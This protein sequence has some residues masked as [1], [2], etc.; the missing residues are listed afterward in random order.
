MDNSPF[1]GIRPAVINSR[2]EFNS[3]PHLGWART[4]TGY[5]CGTQ[6]SVPGQG[7]IFKNQM[8]GF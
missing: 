2:F 1:T 5:C 3:Q 8:Q 6:N 4:T 7:R